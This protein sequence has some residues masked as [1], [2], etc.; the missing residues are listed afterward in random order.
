M[1]KNKQT[2]KRNGKVAGPRTHREVRELR[3]L[4]PC[5][6]CRWH[7]PIRERHLGLERKPAIK[8]P[9]TCSSSVLH[10]STY[11]A[12]REVLWDRRYRVGPRCPADP[13]A[14]RSLEVPTDLRGR[15]VR[16]DRRHRAVRR[17]R[18]PS[19]LWV[20]SFLWHR[21]VRPH[22]RD[23]ENK[24]RTRLRKHWTRRERKKT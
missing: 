7:R 22:R 2:N 9:G 3:W 16:A 14:R 15:A 18:R 12:D 24:R 20:R 17:R 4:R 23:L 21:R 8:S 19:R 1:V 13:K 5:R 11:P 10:A 6:P